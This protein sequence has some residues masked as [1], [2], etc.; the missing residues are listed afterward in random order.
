M[1]DTGV[2]S[3]LMRNPPLDHR[4]HGRIHDIV[5]GHPFP[6]QPARS[7]RG[8]GMAR[9]ARSGRLTRARV[10][11]VSVAAIALML[12]LAAAPPAPAAGDPLLHQ[13]WALSEPAAIG[14]PEA[15]T[16]SRGVGVVVAV[17]DSGVRLNHPD[18]GQNLWRNPSEVPS[19][20]IDDDNNGYVDDVHGA[21][22]KA[23]NGDVE[24]DNGHG[25]HVAGIVAARGNN[26]IGGAGIA[27]GAMIM[28]VKVLDAQ[29][30]GDSSQLAR[31]I[32]YAIDEGARILNVSVNGDVLN[33]DLDDA[34]KYASKRGA[35]IVAST[36]ND[37]RDLDFKPSYPASSSNAAVLSVT[38]IQLGGALVP[39]ANYGL[40]SVD[41]AAPGA[42]ILSTARTGYELRD[43]TSMATPFVS[44]SLA[45]L[46][47]ARPDLP[48]GLLSLA[49]ARSA[50]RS[51]LY[52]GLL[53]FGGLNVGAA[54]RLVLPGALWRTAEPTGVDAILRVSIN[55]QRR[56]RAGG[57][58]TLRW[59]VNDA[60]RV[61]AWRVLLDGHR[62]RTL[63]RSSTMLRKRI[64]RP[65]QHRW[66]VVAIDAKGERIAAAERVFR[67]LVRR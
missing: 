48:Q 5:A 43:G 58:A 7:V 28:P 41:L 19:N 4:M 52:V 31:G 57:E 42:G 32:R 39:R 34:L 14:A 60:R 51:S 10:R 46:A 37:D 2:N 47:A 29:R 56:V 8:G 12:C 61:A 25:T 67:V 21:N 49:L 54:M 22:I 1:I 9:G 23:R 26:G 16:Q 45:L 63:P 36:G 15:W 20:G 35:T 38:S 11:S 65:G 55:A 24:D 64:D 27:P 50:T 13:Q 30:A 33:T 3:A 18:L 62:V 40:R 66:K 6:E 44:G 17:L 53:G 59:M